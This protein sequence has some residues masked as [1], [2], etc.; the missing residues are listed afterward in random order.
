MSVWPLA[1]RLGCTSGVWNAGERAGAQAWPEPAFQDQLTGGGPVGDVGDVEMRAV[2]AGTGD[3]Q[4]LEPPL[5]TQPNLLYPPRD[6]SGE[7]DLRPL[8]V[9]KQRRAMDTVIALGHQHLGANTHQVRAH[10]RNLGHRV[11]VTNDLL[12]RAQQRHCQS[13][14]DRDIH[15][16]SRSVAAA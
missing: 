12:W 8:A 2:V 7:D 11:G 6:R 10:Q 16:A 3:H 5:G 13:A 14:L 1:N 4:N 9:T 15:N